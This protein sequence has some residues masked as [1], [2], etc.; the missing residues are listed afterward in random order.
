MSVIVLEYVVFVLVVQVK[1]L[2]LVGF[3]IR[4]RLMVEFFFVFWGIL[5]I[6]QSYLC[7]L[8]AEFVVGFGLRFYLV[9]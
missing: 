7:Y 1:K 8:E 6:I 2:V 3:K 9:Q 5:D 4:E